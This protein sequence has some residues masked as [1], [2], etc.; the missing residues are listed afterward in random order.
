MRVSIE[1]DE[2]LGITVDKKNQTVKVR[3]GKEFVERLRKGEEADLI[4]PVKMR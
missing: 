3:V 4:L 2:E 1:V